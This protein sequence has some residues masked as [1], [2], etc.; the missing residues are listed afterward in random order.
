MSSHEIELSDFYEKVAVKET[1]AYKHALIKIAEKVDEIIASGSLTLAQVEEINILSLALVDPMTDMVVARS[2]QE[3]TAFSNSKDAWINELRLP[4]SKRLDPLI[5]SDLTYTDSSGADRKYN[6]VRPYSF[7]ENLVRLNVEEKLSKTSPKPEDL[8][9]YYFALEHDQAQSNSKVFSAQL[10][11]IRSKYNGIEVLNKP[12]E[13]E[14][15][16]GER[17]ELEKIVNSQ[18]IVELESWV[19]EATLNQILRNVS[20]FKGGFDDDLEPV[21]L[22]DEILSHLVGIN[23]AISSFQAKMNVNPDKSEYLLEMGLPIF[24]KNPDKIV[25][26]KTFISKIIDM[27]SKIGTA[28]QVDP[29]FQGLK[30]HIDYYAVDG[31]PLIEYL[32]TIGELAEKGFSGLPVDVLRDKYF[33]LELLSSNLAAEVKWIQESTDPYYKIESNKQRAIEYI[34][35]KILSLSPLLSALELAQKDV[36]AKEKLDIEEKIK[37]ELAEGDKRLESIQVRDELAFRY[38]A[39]G[40]DDINAIAMEWKRIWGLDPSD[41]HRFWHYLDTE[42][43]TEFER[44]YGDYSETHPFKETSS[45]KKYE[46]LIQFL[47]TGL[48]EKEKDH[49]SHYFHHYFENRLSLA[50]KA[51][52][53][54]V[55]GSGFVDFYASIQGA[56]PGYGRHTLEFFTAGSPPKEGESRYEFARIV[57]SMDILM[58]QYY[59]ELPANFVQQQDDNGNYI[60]YD[61]GDPV[62]GVYREVYVVRNKNGE[63]IAEVYGDLK[64]EM[65]ANALMLK[66]SRD[67]QVVQ[68]EKDRYNINLITN[69]FKSDNPSVSDFIVERKYSDI[70]HETP[71]GEVRTQPSEPIGHFS[72]ARGRWTNEYSGY[73]QRMYKRLE[74]DFACLQGVKKVVDPNTGEFLHYEVN[75]YNRVIEKN[76]KVDKPVTLIIDKQRIKEII[77]ISA[78]VNFSLASRAEI[79]ASLYYAIGKSPN[80]DPNISGIMMESF[81]LAKELNLAKAVNTVVEIPFIVSGGDISDEW[82]MQTAVQIGLLSQVLF[83]RV[84]GYPYKS[85]PNTPERQIEEAERKEKE[86][87]RQEVFGHF[88]KE[89]ATQ[90]GKPVNRLSE[91]DFSEFA[92]KSGDMPEE[93]WLLR[94]IRESEQKNVEGNTD[95]NRFRAILRAVHVSRLK[96]DFLGLNF[97]TN[98]VTGKNGNALGMYANSSGATNF[99]GQ[100]VNH[101]AA[102]V[103]TPRTQVATH[104]LEDLNLN[105]PQ[106]DIK[107]GER[108]RLDNQFKDMH[109]T[110]QKLWQKLSEPLPTMSDKLSSNVNA[111]VSKVNEMLDLTSSLKKNEKMFNWKLYLDIVQMKLTSLI[112]SYREKHDSVFARK[113]RTLW[114][115]I[116]LKPKD[117]TQL[118]GKLRDAL[119]KSGQVYVGSHIFGNVETM[120]KL[121]KALIPNRERNSILLSRKFYRNII[122]G[123]L[124]GRPEKGTVSEASEGLYAGGMSQRIPITVNTSNYVKALERFDATGNLDPDTAFLTNENML[125]T[126][127]AKTQQTVDAQKDEVKAEKKAHH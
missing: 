78:E 70:Y 109:E 38:Q 118:V 99:D 74:E 83:N 76:K 93:R 34:Q 98:R 80:D 63:A 59:D 3:P 94:I 111:I 115:F 58:T 22:D 6:H 49:E 127:S 36:G 125:N 124:M 46:G 85:E 68:E 75:T 57:R 64:K 113:H 48:Q 60:F 32:K 35:N 81:P 90:L 1:K 54:G 17:V 77:E 114:E 27:N 112:F 2:K 26:I 18:K 19:K 30:Y 33:K 20:V 52:T 62:Q 86:A 126:A 61:N 43:R 23:K 9:P 97:V 95:I 16:A 110:A 31:R 100:L 121:L 12:D 84:T 55:S 106:H 39:P 8:Q 82:F 29:V 11:S 91:A 25:K 50:D 4:L 123:V 21:K 116:M 13:I 24:A 88:F 65:W 66:G 87:A 71:D 15:P 72:F 119:Q 37:K 14:L 53:H 73:K 92:P 10:E 103:D 56:F 69:K 41:K 51:Y 67:R 7:I 5:A 96:R 47:S 102:L 42:V 89:M 101:L 107:I 108:H 45:G 105:T 79:F 104:A 40:R 28:E 122:V 44:E 117:R 120:S